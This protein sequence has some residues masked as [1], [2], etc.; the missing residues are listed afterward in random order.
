MSSGNKKP[1]E[2]VLIAQAE[3]CSGSMGMVNVGGFVEMGDF[4][5]SSF[6]IEWEKEERQRMGRRWSDD[7]VEVDDEDNLDDDD[8]SDG[9]TDEDDAEEIKALQCRFLSLLYFQ[10]S[11]NLHS[12]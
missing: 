2:K 9:G 10:Q 11:S 7:T 4:G 1:D 8:I 12:R 5:Q 3:M 6:R